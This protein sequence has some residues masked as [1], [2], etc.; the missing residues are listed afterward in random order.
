MRSLPMVGL[1]ARVKIRTLLTFTVLVAAFPSSSPARA[2]EPPP[3]APSA[4]KVCFPAASE[5]TQAVGKALTFTSTVTR[6]VRSY[7]VTWSYAPVWCVSSLSRDELT[8]RSGWRSTVTG[9]PSKIT[10]ADLTAAFAKFNQSTISESW[11]IRD[12]RNRVVATKFA[13]RDAEHLRPSVLV[14]PGKIPTSCTECSWY[15]PRSGP[16]ALTGPLVFVDLTTSGTWCVAA[17]LSW[18]QS[19]PS[20]IADTATCPVRKP[21]RWSSLPPGRYRVEFTATFNKGSSAGGV[22]PTGTRISATGVSVTVPGR[23]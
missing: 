1:S 6:G 21:L 8:F 2:V 9:T 5:G 7:P 10:S 22:S 11:V 12:R 14:L 4:D 3:P 20:A 16:Q 19:T 17:D 23:P 18:R 13:A 15:A